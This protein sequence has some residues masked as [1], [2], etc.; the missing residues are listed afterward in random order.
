MYAYLDPPFRTGL[1]SMLP[2]IGIIILG[3][4]VSLAGLGPL[5]LAVGL[6]GPGMTYLGSRDMTRTP[7]APPQTG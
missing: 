1:A 2:G 6:V 4:T 7:G 3:A 5:G